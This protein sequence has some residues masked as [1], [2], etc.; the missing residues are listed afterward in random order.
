MTNE[1]RKQEALMRRDEVVEYFL[2]TG[3][4]TREIAAYFTEHYYPISNKT[5]SK[6]IHDYMVEVP[7]SKA[8]LTEKIEN[9]K[10][11]DFLTE[12]IKK[13]ILIEFELL[14]RGYNIT[15]IASLV[16]KGYSSVQ[17]DLTTRLERLAIADESYEEY[18][19]KAQEIIRGNQQFGSKENRRASK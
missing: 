7:S 18:Y 19:N 4:S 13:Q 15:Q 1:E 3:A 16:D 2:Q 8:R 9:N 10:E 6:Y 14:L 5:V 11:K 12:E 17:R